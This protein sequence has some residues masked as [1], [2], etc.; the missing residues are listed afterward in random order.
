MNEE[1]ADE[2]SLGVGGTE[3]QVKSR[4]CFINARKGG[5]VADTQQSVSQSVP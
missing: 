2:G 4:S 1:E 5:T 3:K